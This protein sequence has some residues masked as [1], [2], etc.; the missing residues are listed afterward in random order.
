MN[1][2]LTQ[3]LFPSNLTF[4]QILHSPLKDAPTKG[5]TGK[6]IHLIHAFFFCNYIFLL[7]YI[8][9]K[10]NSKPIEYLIQ[11]FCA[12]YWH[13]VQSIWGPLVI[14]IVMFEML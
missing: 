12:N 5:E 14:F 11:C 13:S 4:F 9:I 10:V 3:I 6:A 8:S 1:F 2:I 7:V